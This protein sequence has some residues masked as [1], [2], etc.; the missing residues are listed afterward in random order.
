MYRS[1]AL[2]KSKNNFIPNPDGIFSACDHNFP[3][4]LLKNARNG[5]YISKIPKWPSSRSLALKSKLMRQFE[6]LGNFEYM[7]ENDW[8]AIFHTNLF[9][10]FKIRTV[11]KS[12]SG[13]SNLAMFLTCFFH[14]WHLKLQPK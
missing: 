6:F 13:A 1:T 7:M 2:I 3:K 4:I 11:I 9:S 14:F 5:K 8:R 12:H 10:F